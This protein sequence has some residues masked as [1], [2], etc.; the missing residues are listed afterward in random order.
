MHTLGPNVVQS[1][2][3]TTEYDKKSLIEEI[4]SVYGDSLKNV[5]V[6]V[7]SKI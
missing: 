2:V 1:Y 7:I 4:T 5:E 3:T 6:N